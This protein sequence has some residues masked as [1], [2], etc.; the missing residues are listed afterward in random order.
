VGIAYVLFGIPGS[1]YMWYR[2]I[3]LACISRRASYFFISM[4][5]MFISC[6]FW[7]IACCGFPGTYQ[8]GMWIMLQ[9]FNNADCPSGDS[10]CEDNKG[11]YEF[12]GFWMLIQFAMEIGLAC[13]SCYLLMRLRQLYNGNGGA[14][15]AKTDAAQTAAQDPTVQRAVIEGAKASASNKL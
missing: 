7:I 4:C 8:G 10:N 1:F 12:T 11:A 14:A 15:A 9:Q 3:Y 6:A 5:T 2:I 13:A